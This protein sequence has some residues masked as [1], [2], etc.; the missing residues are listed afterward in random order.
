MTSNVFLSCH[1]QYQLVI[2]LVL[3]RKLLTLLYLSLH[4]LGVLGPPLLG[5]ARAAA[6]PFQKGAWKFMPWPADAL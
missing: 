2:L 6:T 4:P 5:L 3:G 1:R